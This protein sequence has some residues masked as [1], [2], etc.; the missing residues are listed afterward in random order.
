M[1]GSYLE[2]LKLLRR[3]PAVRPVFRAL[4]QVDHAAAA[5]VK[6]IEHRAVM[7]CQESIRHMNAVV[8]IDTDQM[9]IGLRMVNL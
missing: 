7:S 6:R 8:R 2:L 3:A 4:G 1:S 5:L 9:S